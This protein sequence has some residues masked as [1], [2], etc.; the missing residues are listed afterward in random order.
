MGDDIEQRYSQ[1]L[2]QE[3]KKKFE[4]QFKLKSVF[5]MA[6]NNFSMVCR[7]FLASVQDKLR[8][9]WEQVYLIYYG[10]LVN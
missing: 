5:H 7:Q 3:L 2:T 4:E 6:Y 9:G 1:E 10:M 8:S